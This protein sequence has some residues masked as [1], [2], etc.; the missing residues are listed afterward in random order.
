MI[1]GNLY[2]GF[3]GADEW[4]DAAFG[5]DGARTNGQG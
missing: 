4:D 1:L 3:E 5:F 2:K